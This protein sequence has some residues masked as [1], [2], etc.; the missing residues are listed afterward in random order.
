MNTWIKNI[1]KLDL[2]RHLTANMTPDFINKLIEKNNLSSNSKPL[3]KSGNNQLFTTSIAFFEYH[4]FARSSI[5]DY[6]DFR[7]LAGLIVSQLEADNVIYTELLFSPNFM[8][9]R[10][11]LSIQ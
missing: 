8:L 2:H 9:I 11:L 3:F 4:T 1:P 7:D 6:S 10:V 5:R